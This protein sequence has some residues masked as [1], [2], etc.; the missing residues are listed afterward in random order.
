MFLPMAVAHQ[1]RRIL[2]KRI[3]FE[4]MNS[5]LRIHSSMPDMEEDVMSATDRI[6]I[7]E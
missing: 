1:Q 7:L 2:K 3:A 4:A 6:I 5:I